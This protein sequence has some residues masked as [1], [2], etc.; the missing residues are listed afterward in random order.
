M[1]K[2][3]NQNPEQI[4]RDTIDK[5]LTEAGWVVQSKNDVDIHASK[6]VAVREY[7]TDIG[8]ADYVL[9]VN[10]KQVHC[11][12]CF[13]CFCRQATTLIG[14]KPDRLIALLVL[15]IWVYRRIGNHRCNFNQLQYKQVQRVALK[16]QADAT[17]CG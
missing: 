13:D 16:V 17:P 7:Q 14:L 1:P 12:A 5:M 15:K 11:K 4:A 10:Q 9:F 3:Y 2:E 6:G 8:P